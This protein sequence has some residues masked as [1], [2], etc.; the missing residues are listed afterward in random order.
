MQPPYRVFLF[1]QL[2]KYFSPVREMNS[3]GIKKAC[4][5]EAIG[6]NGHPAGLITIFLLALA[7]IRRI[8][9]TGKYFQEKVVFLV[10]KYYFCREIYNIIRYGRK[11]L[12]EKDL[13]AH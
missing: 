4:G 2:G 6:D 8:F 7:K 13:N 12:S 1:P 5:Q 3:R 11:L 9:G 10:G